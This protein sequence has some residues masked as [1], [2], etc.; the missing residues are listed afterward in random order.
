MSA[1]FNAATKLRLFPDL[2]ANHGIG[3]YYLKIDRICV[4]RLQLRAPSVARPCETRRFAPKHEA[5]PDCGG[6]LRPLGEDVPET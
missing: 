5:C 2:G 3:E 1:I 4:F 6:T